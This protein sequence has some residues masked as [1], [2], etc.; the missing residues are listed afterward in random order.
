MDLHLV[1]L[2]PIGLT[3]SKRSEQYEL[4]TNDIPETAGVYIFGRGHGEA[5]E[6]LYVGL[7]ANLRFRIK[8]QL[9]NHRLMRHL[10]RAKT[11]VRGVII[12][13]WRPR[14]GQT[15][16]KCLPL[17]ER[18]LIRH[19]VLE[20]HDLVNKNGASLRQHTITSRGRLRSFLP[21]RL[22]LDKQ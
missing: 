17:I 13:E 20:G 10:E 19:F 4:D 7:A 18:S 11:G 15:L 3:W 6:A 5:I 22:Y 8:Q 2:K 12:A 16:K 1:W 9:N 14:P 21:Q